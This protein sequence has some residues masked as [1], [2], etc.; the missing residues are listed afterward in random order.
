M[1]AAHALFPGFVIDRIWNIVAATPAGERLLA[2][3]AERNMIRLLFDQH[4][5]WREL[6]DNLEHVAAYGLAQRQDDV[7]RFTHHVQPRALARLALARA[8][9]TGRP[10]AASCASPR[11]CRAENSSTPSV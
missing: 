11:L 1:L 7:L 5:A 10:A 3:N 9:H 4:G 2:G 6:L 8:T